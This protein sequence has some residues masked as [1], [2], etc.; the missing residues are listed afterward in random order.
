MQR[1]LIDTASTFTNS[2][3]RVLDSG[4]KIILRRNKSKATSPRSQVASPTNQ[5]KSPTEQQD[6]AF[7]E[8]AMQQDPD[9]TS[10]TVNTPSISTPD[11]SNSG[12]N[13][14]QGY[15]AMDVL[16]EA[17]FLLGFGEL[18]SQTSQASQIPQN[19]DDGTNAGFEFSPIGNQVASPS[20]SD[21]ASGVDLVT[22]PR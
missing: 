7:A 15:G 6:D 12:N 2:V 22:P 21:V 17:S 10:M 8:M 16:R 18:A 11:G 1:T 20:G 13:T 4:A 19:Y 3:Q 14:E 5:A 9:A